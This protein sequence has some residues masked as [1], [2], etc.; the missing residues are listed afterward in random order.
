MSTRSNFKTGGRVLLFFLSLCVSA[1][2]FS[3]GSKPTDLRALVPADSLIYLETNDLAAAIGPIV[4]NEAFSGLNGR[5]DI[6]ALKGI[7]LA[8]AVSGFSLSEEKVTGEH[9]VARV[10]PT[11]VAIAD[12]HA[13]NWQAVA[14]A[15]QKIGEFVMDI[16]R[17]DVTQDRA[18]KHGGQYFTWTAADGR[19]AHALVIG[20]LVYFGNDE[21][22]LERCLS[23]SRGEIES[24]ANG[25]KVTQ[26]Q[27]S[28]LASGYVSS[29]GVAQIA[30][31]VALMSANEMGDAAEVQSVIAAILPQILRGT[32]SEVRWTA[33]RPEAPIEAGRLEDRYSIT[34]PEEIAR[35]F[36][37]T[38]APSGNRDRTLFDSI[39]NDILVATHYDLA[40]PN[41]AWRGLLLTSQTLIDGPAG[42]L[43]APFSST[44]AEPYGV[45]DPELYLSGVGPSIL[46]GNIDPTADKPFVIASMVIPP[47][48][49]AS[50]DPELKPDKPL[51]D[52][53]GF[54][55]MKNADGDLAAAF[56]DGK[57]LSGSLDAVVACLRARAAGTVLSKSA[58][59][60]DLAVTGATATSLQVD[61]DIGPAIA[62]VLF[63]SE[64]G[65]V[66]AGSVYNIETRFSRT[67]IERRTVS[68][69]GLIGWIISQFGSN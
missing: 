35:V 65:Q 1:V 13:W 43:V 11:F 39:P 37:E 16:Y 2:S 42:T 29:D 30:S 40:K 25:G 52:E 45:R 66:K 12:T 49:K 55:V 27:A 51:S 61:R 59:V 54:E 68:D 48:V 56:F 46:T 8:V 3:C 60:V 17:S 33:A 47:N 38:L 14:F 57:V 18:D 34:S 26:I 36:A 6:S 24:I 50:L 28:A 22:A 41:I 63:G 5:P 21:A 62:A 9:S 58:A 32:V 23:V 20:S 64:A 53:F 67:G 69:F 15:E 10:Q 31:I 44:F 4:E 19:R 7:Q